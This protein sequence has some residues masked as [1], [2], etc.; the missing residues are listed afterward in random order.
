[1]N[2]IIIIII[3]QLGLL[4]SSNCH[5]STIQ[6]KEDINEKGKKNGIINNL[7]PRESLVKGTE[8]SS[9]IIQKIGARI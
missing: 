6:P 5:A 7:T 8:L 3:I 9:K 2:K 1:M 4:I